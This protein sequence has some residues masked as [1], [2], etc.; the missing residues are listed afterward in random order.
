M[1]RFVDKTWETKSREEILAKRNELMQAMQDELDSN[2]EY[3][4]AQGW[5]SHGSNYDLMSEDTQAYYAD[6]I[7][8]LYSLLTR[9]GEEN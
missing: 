2:A 9:F 1:L 4:E 8:Y 5:P 6:D 3:C 7:D